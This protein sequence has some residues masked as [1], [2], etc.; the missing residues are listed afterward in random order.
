MSGKNFPHRSLFRK[1]EQTHD[2]N[3]TVKQQSNRTINYV[4]TTAITKIHFGS[5]SFLLSFQTTVSEQR[6][7]SFS[8][9]RSRFLLLS[10]PPTL[11]FSASF[12]TLW[13][14]KTGFLALL[15]PAVRS[16]KL[17]YGL[18]LFVYVLLDTSEAKNF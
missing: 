1:A 4:Y 15:I 6:W 11:F 2:N 14:K 16:W 5:S 3:A 18:Y 7:A 9:G 10:F 13:N 8:P 17:K 12:F